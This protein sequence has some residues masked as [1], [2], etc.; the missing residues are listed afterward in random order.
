MKY[1]G[2]LGRVITEFRH[3]LCGILYIVVLGLFCGCLCGD[4]STSPDQQ[5]EKGEESGEEQCQQGY[6]I[7]GNGTRVRGSLIDVNSFSLTSQKDY[8][9]SLCGVD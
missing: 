4:T 5:G 6:P 8:L 2:K 3:A 1:H 7:M 9:Q